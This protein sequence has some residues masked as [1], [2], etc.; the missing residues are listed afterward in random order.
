MK[1]QGGWE[2]KTI[3]SSFLGQSKTAW[4]LWHQLPPE[5]EEASVLGDG[6]WVS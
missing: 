6:R 4:A 5:D 1:E 2:F 3:V